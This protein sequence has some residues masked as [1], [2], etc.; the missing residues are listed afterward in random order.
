M[1]LKQILREVAGTYGFYNPEKDSEVR[2]I[3]PTGRTDHAVFARANP[4]LFGLSEED[5]P[6]EIVEDGKIDMD[7]VL[8]FLF[9]NGWVRINYFKGGWNFHG[10]NIKTVRNTIKHYYEKIEFNEAVIDIGE[11]ADSPDISTTLYPEDKIIR[12]IKSG[13]LT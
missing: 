6:E 3:D 7:I 4:H 2:I 10:G 5:F 13:K 9:H 11:Y 8:S 12:F 1:R